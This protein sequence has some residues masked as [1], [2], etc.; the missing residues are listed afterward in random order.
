MEFG[1][2]GQGEAYSI[3]S[4]HQPRMDACSPFTVLEKLFMPQSRIQN[5]LLVD[6]GAI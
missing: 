4:S 5:S 1:F 2:F 3:K 6:Q